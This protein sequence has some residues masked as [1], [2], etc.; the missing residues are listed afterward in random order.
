[1]AILASA[2]DA[3]EEASIDEAYVDFSSLGDFE[4]ACERAN[5]LKREIAEREGLTARWARPN[6]PVAKIA[7]DF[8]KPTA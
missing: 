1:M 3:F 6:K 2:G 7:S 4:A 5:A 8:S